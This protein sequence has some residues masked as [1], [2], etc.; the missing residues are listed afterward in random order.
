MGKDLLKISQFVGLVIFII[1]FIVAI[2]ISKIKTVQS[3]FNFFWIYS[4]IGFI[5]CFL[6]FLANL[7]F[8]KSNSINSINLVSLL[9][10]YSFISYVFF[11][12]N[13]TQKIFKWVAIILF[14]VIAIFIKIDLSNNNTMTSFSVA[15]GTLFCFALYFLVKYLQADSIINLTNI[16]LFFICTGILIGTMFIMPTSFML[17]YLYEIKS[18]RNAMYYFACLS[19]IGYIIIN[20]FFI[21]ALLVAQKTVWILNKKKT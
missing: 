21:K 2:R 10:H 14:I 4:L 5:I 18:A 9:F 3:P 7:K 11:K 8:V 12:D 16:P 19:S 6:Y 15:N 1:Q 20:L 17:K 13:Y